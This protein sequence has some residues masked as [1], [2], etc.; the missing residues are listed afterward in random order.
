MNRS[1]ALVIAFDRTNARFLSTLFSLNQLLLDRIRSITHFH[2]F[3]LLRYGIIRAH[4]FV[5]TKVTCWLYGLL[6]QI[7][8]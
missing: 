3:N 7:E 4:L 6:L 8:R 2:H 5:E 1:F